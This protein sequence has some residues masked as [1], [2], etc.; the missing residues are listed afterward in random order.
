[1]TEYNF[2]NVDVSVCVDGRTLRIFAAP[3]VVKSDEVVQS[4]E[5]ETDFLRIIITY[6]IYTSIYTSVVGLILKIVSF[7]WGWPFS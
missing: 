3:I 2:K 4:D 5:P 6:V 1:M 7:F